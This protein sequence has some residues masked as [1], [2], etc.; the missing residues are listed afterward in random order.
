MGLETIQA[1]TRRNVISNPRLG[2]GESATSRHNNWRPQG[3][4]NPCCHRERVVQR[5]AGAHFCGTVWARKPTMS[6]YSDNSDLNVVRLC[7]LPIPSKGVP[8]LPRN[9]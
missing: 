5:P 2:L 9:T 7:L 3:D 8:E 4:S 1:E 6:D